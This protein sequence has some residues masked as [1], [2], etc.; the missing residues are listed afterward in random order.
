MAQCPC[1]PLSAGADYGRR[2]I[3]AGRCG[4]LSRPALT[5]TAGPSA[6]AATAGDVEAAANG[7][8]R[9]GDVRPAASDRY[10]WPYKM[11]MEAGR[12]SSGTRT[13]P[14]RPPWRPSFR[15]WG[16]RGSN[17]D[18]RIKRRPLDRSERTACT[19]VPRICPESTHCTQSPPAPVPRAV[20]RNLRRA[21]P[22]PSPSVAER[23]SR[24]AGAGEKGSAGRVR[25]GGPRC[26][27]GGGPA[28][29]A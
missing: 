2:A 17:S 29:V 3:R 8:H 4:A 15:R 7:R 5:A 27:Q 16:V 21:G 26:P 1:Q 22:S 9:I 12:R 13:V 23:R 24:G 25:R 20:P 14:R 11:A 18:P 28:D 19:D 10:A 6:D